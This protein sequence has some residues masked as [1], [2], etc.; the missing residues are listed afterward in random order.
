MS[1]AAIY[2]PVELEDVPGP[3]AFSGTRERFFS[4]LWLS[5]RMEFKVRYA[6][7]ILGYG[8]ALLQPLALF[9]VLY[10]VFTQVFGFGD[11]VPYYGAMIVIN[12]VLFTFF[13]ETVSGA[14]PSVLRSES[15]VRK[16]QF[17]R[18]VVPLGTVVTG[19]LTL[20]FNLVV[21][22][23]FLV[24]ADTSIRWTWLFLPLIIFLLLIFTA[25]V[26]MLLS[27]LYAKYRDISQAWTVIA[28]VL[29]YATPV[30]FPIELVGAT[31]RQFFVA[32]PLAP[33]FIE[34]RRAFFDPGAMGTF[35]A[36]GGPI[37]IIISA[38][39]FVGISV[40]GIWYFVRRAP[41]IAEDL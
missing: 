22:S 17:P 16:T 34:V 37:P 33:I 28:R 35:E 5:A 6:D 10:V 2:R 11:T 23:L 32:N 7:S 25:S 12:I 39:L 31:L 14:V 19:L 29:F 30:L 13:V 20:L 24:I 4:L 1:E 26:S 15:V 8:W 38:V 40:T 3:S 21:V 36:A 18:A 41:Q 27:A 9:S